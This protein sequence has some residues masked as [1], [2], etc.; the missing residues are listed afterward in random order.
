VSE[1]G[2]I[3]AQEG[4]GHEEDLEDEEQGEKEESNDDDQQQQQQQQQQKEQEK[5]EEEEGG[6]GEA[7]TASSQALAAHQQQMDGDVDHALDEGAGSSRSRA[8]TTWKR[9]SNLGT[10]GIKAAKFGPVNKKKAQQAHAVSAFTS[11][12]L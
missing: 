7:P 9:V 1:E 8:S 2:G 6:V 3:E 10:V 12:K 5:K 4:G 11:T